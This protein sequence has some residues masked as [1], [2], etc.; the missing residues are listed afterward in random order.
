[1]GVAKAVDSAGH[2]IMLTK[3]KNRYYRFD[4]IQ[5]EML[6]RAGISCRYAG[7]LCDAVSDARDKERPAV[8]LG[9]TAM[10]PEIKGYIEGRI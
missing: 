2:D 10:L 8:I 1:M 4:G 5:Q 7:S 3:V 6:K 9:T